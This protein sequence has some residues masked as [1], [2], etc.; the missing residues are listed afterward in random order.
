MNHFL[1]DKLSAMT[2]RE[3]A[4]VVAREGGYLD[5][6]RKMRHTLRQ[7]GELRN[8]SLSIAALFVAAMTLEPL[9]WFSPSRSTYVGEV[10]R[11]ASNI[12]GVPT[13][14]LF[15]DVLDRCCINVG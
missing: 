7:K 4:H 1:S 13:V 10:T 15:N 5:F 9:R 14:A 3:R 12:S 6:P 11:E 2:S 8:L